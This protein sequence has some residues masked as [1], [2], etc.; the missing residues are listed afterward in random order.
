LDEETN[1]YLS[2]I[3]DSAKQMGRLIDDLLT[4]SRTGRA[5]LRKTRLSLDEL[6]A[7]VIRDLQPETEN[8]EVTWEVAELPEVEADPALLRQVMLNLVSNA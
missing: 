1:R 2:T 7:G 3:S 6:A 5:E 4:F 8:R